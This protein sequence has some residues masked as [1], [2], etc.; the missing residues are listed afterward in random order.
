MR[1]RTRRGPGNSINHRSVFAPD[2]STSV[3]VC[4]FRPRAGL[5]FASASVASQRPDD[6]DAVETSHPPADT[7]PKTEPTR[8][9]PPAPHTTHGSISGSQDTLFIDHPI[10]RL[11][12]QIS[13]QNPLAIQLYG[14]LNQGVTLNPDLP[15][16]RTNGPVLSNYRSHEYQMKGL[17]MIAERKVDSDPDAASNPVAAST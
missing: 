8:C 7:P 6:S 3:A 1:T 2:P 14:Y 11:L 5:R 17:Y 9:R 12:D 15:R 13:Q 10:A 16:D 4:P